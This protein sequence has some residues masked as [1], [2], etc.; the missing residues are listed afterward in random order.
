MMIEQQV[1]KSGLEEVAAT[2]AEVTLADFAESFGITVEDMPERC[3]EMIAYGNFRYRKAEG[4]KRD[5]II[6]E[7]LKKIAADRQV[8]GASER[9]DVWN[10]GWE[11]SYEG[12][13]RSGYDLARLVPRFIRPGQP[14]RWRQEYIIPENE[15]FEL[16]YFAV[17]REWL[18]E[19][20]CADANAI[21]EFGCG[22]GFNLAALAQRYPDKEFHGFDFVP[23]AKKMLDAM[24]GVYGW[25]MQGHMFDMTAPDARIEFRDNSRLLTFGALEQL[26]GRIEAFFDFVLKRSPSLCVHVE[27]VI[28]LYDEDNL[29]DFLA[30]SFHRKR[31]YTANLLGLLKDLESRGKI[32]LLKVKRSFFGSLF[33]EGYTCLVWRPIG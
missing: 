11:E 1:N 15:W 12:F 4:Q 3:R 17:L 14:I 10:A 5:R 13:V 9:K 24:A 28:D 2:V 8:V 6:L 7:V 26:A 19:T 27:P 21:Y 29:I 16:D 33:M 20:Y 30:A 25:R 23:P 32:E 22:T 31:G 18:F